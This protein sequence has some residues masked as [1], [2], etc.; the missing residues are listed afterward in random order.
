M[1]IYQ[2]PM[3]YHET[4]CQCYTYRCPVGIDHQGISS[5]IDPT[6]YISHMDCI[7]IIENIIWLVECP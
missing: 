2:G 6:D 5:Y 1:D 3:S 4:V 7:F